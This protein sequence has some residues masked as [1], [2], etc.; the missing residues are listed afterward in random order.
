MKQ[1]IKQVEA[2]VAGLLSSW[3][4]VD[5]I[6]IA[7]SADED[8]SD[9]YFFLSL[10]VYYKGELPSIQERRDAFPKAFGF[11]SS[12]LNKKDRFLIDNVPIRIEYKFQ[13]RVDEILE[14]KDKV[15][16]MLREAGTHMFYRLKENRVLVAKTE[17]LE[18]K[19]EQLMQIHDAFW[20]QIADSAK[21]RLEHHVSDIGAA[22]IRQDSYFFAAALSGYLSSLSTL[23]FSLNHQFEPA[24]RWVYE[25]ILHL[26][27]LPDA[28]T[29][30][31]QSLLRFDGSISNAKKHEIAQ[32]LAKSLIFAR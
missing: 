10:D 22:V 26:P 32:L 8:F 20:D 16:G 6:T 25:R 11:E 17:W 14:N 24:P 28:F 23:L 1:K 5:T 29:G 3:D 7:E 19:R 12:A 15:F 18:A 9:P 13:D 21:A 31:F 27:N 30:R 2:D 4:G